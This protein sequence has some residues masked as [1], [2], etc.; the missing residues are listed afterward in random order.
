MVTIVQ[1]SRRQKVRE[2]DFK[3]YKKKLDRLELPLHLSKACK[4]QSSAYKCSVSITVTSTTTPP[5]NTPMARKYTGSSHCA[6]ALDDEFDQLDAQNV[7]VWCYLKRD[8]P[9]GA[10]IITRTVHYR[11]KMDKKGT[12]T[13]YKSRCTR[14]SLGR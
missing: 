11:F 10:D 7:A 12:I 4:A 2:T 6:K 1:T 13:A 8:L 5:M 9:K 14:L 3:P